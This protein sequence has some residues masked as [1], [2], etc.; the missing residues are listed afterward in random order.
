MEYIIGLIVLAVVAYAFFGNKSDTDSVSTT[1]S[2][3]APVSA[4]VADANKNGIVSKAE[5]K[6]LT[7]VQLVEYADKKGLKIKRS[8]TKASVI[9]DI[10]TQL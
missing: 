3:P 9:N 4:P 1:V 7:K 2:T 5:L 6:K 8:G 10:H